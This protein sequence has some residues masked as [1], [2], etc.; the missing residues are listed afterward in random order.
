MII[1]EYDDGIALDVSILIARALNI[2]MTN[3]MSVI[4]NINR[5]ITT[6]LVFDVRRVDKQ[7]RIHRENA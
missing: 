3:I 1:F 5:P 6:L 7:S 4:Q 2:Q